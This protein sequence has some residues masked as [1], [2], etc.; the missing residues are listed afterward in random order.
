MAKLYDN[1]K[2][3]SKPQDI[4]FTKNWPCQD[5]QP[6]NAN[7]CTM[8][9]HNFGVM[10]RQGTDFA[11]WLQNQE[12][13]LFWQETSELLRSISAINTTS[14]TSSS[15]KLIPSASA[16]SIAATDLNKNSPTPPPVANRRR[17]LRG[18]PS[19]SN[20]SDN[21]VK[22]VAKPLML[23]SH[24]QLMQ[25][26]AVKLGVDYKKVSDGIAVEQSLVGLAGIKTSQLGAKFRRQPNGN[27]YF[28]LRFNSAEELNSF[29]S[30][31]NRYFPDFIQK[32]EN[33]VDGQLT[34]IV[35]DTK[36]FYDQ[37][38]DKLE[39]FVIAARQGNS[40]CN[41]C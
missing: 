28:M 32:S 7:N 20:S 18:A 33:Y 11:T 23:P 34:R 17:I 38:A 30:R 2:L 26:L 36:I 39:Q 13:S 4:E 15:A 16:I 31:Y 3:L 22:S 5:K 24:E 10:Y 8:S 40:S 25:H 37:V 35:V 1:N 41:I 9:S 19:S 27:T 14:T 21:I 6:G 12:N 29:V